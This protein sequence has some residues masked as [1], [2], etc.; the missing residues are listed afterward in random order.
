MSTYVPITETCRRVDHRVIWFVALNL[1]KERRTPD[2]FGQEPFV[3]KDRPERLIQIF[4]VPEE[5]PPQHAFLHRPE[6]AQR[7]IPAPVLEGC[8]RLEPMDAEHVE[9]KV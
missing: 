4:P 2:G 8:A 7:A 3:L 1:E 6:L 5:G 9:G